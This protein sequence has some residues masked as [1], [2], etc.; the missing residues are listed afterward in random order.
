MMRRGHVLAVDRPNRRVHG[1]LLDGQEIPAARYLDFPPE[2][3]DEALFWQ[4]SSGS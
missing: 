3:G 2:V 4:V 1:R